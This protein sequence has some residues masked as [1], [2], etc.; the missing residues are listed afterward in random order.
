M[1]FGLSELF[2]SQNIWI[3]IPL[4]AIVGGLLVGVVKLWLNHRH[5]EIE[6]ALKQDMLNRGMS[7]EQIER[8]LNAGKS[9][10]TGDRPSCA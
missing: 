4:T 3:L 5:A 10:G 2:D 7:A 9:T 1:L 8:V 6:A